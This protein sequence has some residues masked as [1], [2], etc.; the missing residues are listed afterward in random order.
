MVGQSV[1]DANCLPMLAV[2]I[3]LRR[4]FVQVC[5]CLEDQ[6]K[7]GCSREELKCTCDFGG[8]FTTFK[9]EIYKLRLIL[10][11]SNYVPVKNSSAP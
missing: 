7:S 4:K 1:T 10:G 2:Y 3:G 5:L 9:V 11:L 8:L 6:R